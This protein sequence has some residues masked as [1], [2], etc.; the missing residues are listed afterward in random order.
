[1]TKLPA[2]VRSLVARQVTSVDAP[3]EL[4][5]SDPVADVERLLAL[6]RQAGEGVA[7]RVLQREAE[8]DGADRRGREQPIA[9]EGRA[10]SDQADDDEVLEDRREAIRH[11][12]EPQRVDR[13]Q[14]RAR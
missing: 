3:L 2:F 6:D 9:E 10:T 4:A 13:D 7:E 1:M 8:H 14:D 12:I 11:A 5:D